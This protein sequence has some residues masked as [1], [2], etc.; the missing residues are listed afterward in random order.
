ML[1]FILGSPLTGLA[2]GANA[3]LSGQI[4]D[5]GGAVIQGASLT[6]RNVDT[7]LKQAAVSNDSGLYQ[8]SALPP[9][10]YTLTIEKQGFQRSVQTGITLTVGQAATLNVSLQLGNVA[11]TVTVTSDAELVN[12]TTA[13]IGQVVNQESVRELPLNGRDPSSLVL[14]TTGMS[15]VLNASG[16]ASYKSSVA[17]P[18]ETGA[19][20][21]GGRQGS[22]YYL[23]DGAPNMDTNLLLA[24]PFPNADATQEFRAVTNN[25]DAHYGFSPGAV[26]SVETK[27]GTNDFHGG[28]FEFVRNND[29]NASDY[30]SHLVD[31]LKRNQLGAFVGG[32][33]IKNKLFFFANYQATIASMQ[34]TGSSTYAPTTA[35]MNG[36]FSAISTSLSTSAGFNAQNQIDPSLFSTVAVKLATTVYPKS[37]AS[38]GLVQYSTAP[39]TYKYNEG[40]ARIDYNISDTQRLMVRSFI[41][42]T[43]QPAAATSG[44]ALSSVAGRLGKYYN[45]TVGHTWTISPTMVNSFNA[46]WTEMN[47]ASTEKSEDSSGN[48]V[49]LSKYI[50]VST[51]TG[52]CDFLGIEISGGFQ[53]IWGMT[54]SMLR[55]TFGINEAFTYLH[56]NHTVTAGGV[57]WHQRMEDYVDFPVSPLVEFW[58]GYSGNAFA[59]FLLGKASYFEQGGGEIAHVAGWQL[60]LFAQ[61]QY[62]IK[63]NL[64]LTAGLRWDPNIPPTVPLGR[65]SA[66][67]AGQQS[68]RYP[69][70]PLGLVFPGDTGVNSALM[71]T[72]YNYYEPR[73][74][75]AWQPKSL[76]HTSMRAGFGMFTGPLPYTFY[77]HAASM[78]PWS[79]TY[80]FDV[81]AGTISF[82]DPWTSQGMS[83]PYPPFAS[84]SY[85]P[86]STYTF[87]GATQVGMGFSSNFRLG[88][89]QSWNASIDQ[90]FARDFALHLTYVGSESYKQAIEEDMNPGG[91]GISI[92]TYGVRPDSALGQVIQDQSRGNSSYHSLQI[93][94]EKHYSHNFQFASNFTW[95]KT[96]DIASTGDPSQSGTTIDNPYD[97]QWSRGISDLNV[98]LIWV[99]NFVYSTPKLRNQKSLTRS[100]V[101]EWQISGI[102]SMQ[103]GAP[104]ASRVEMAT[105]ILDRYSPLASMVTVRISLRGS[106]G[107]NIAVQ[108]ATG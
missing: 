17:M 47:V 56:G 30:F 93:G 96:I 31:P 67:R 27:S 4:I 57:L 20:S 38:D 72:S 84:Y 105:V 22:T 24:A 8:I 95:S 7:G 32:P 3:N 21:G 51:E 40:T 62:K 44:N 14:L 25:F 43:N 79:P 29:L 94:I 37:S 10:H 9:G 45:E 16:N 18:T 101:G 98:P 87:V 78:A 71:P 89:T 77:S 23:L 50:D 35:M 55:T 68:T 15:N 91:N 99:T 106:H 49:C 2:Q 58:G 36:D 90:Q 12:T 65:G 73:I 103:S 1:L 64:T 5:P 83:N 97:L 102:W 13:E 86:G 100:V 52:V 6:I 85:N 88:M 11:E 104:S 69:N 74:G 39:Y 80:T 46:F 75:L 42:Y 60:G 92:G 81:S 107:I 41:Q 61:D 34:G 54:Y 33:I 28:A 63:P 53:P 108:R 82:E 70:A 48:T 19:S 76:P 66:Y 26:V 59:D